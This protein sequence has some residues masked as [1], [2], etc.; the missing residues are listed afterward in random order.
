VLLGRSLGAAIAAELAQ[1]RAA[2]AVILE[3]PFK[4][5]PAVA[6]DV[7]PFL[8]ARWLA[9]IEYPTVRYVRNI[10]TPLLVIHSR[11]DEIIPFAH[12]RAVYDAANAPKRFLPITGGHNTGFTE[13][14]ERYTQGIDRFLTAVAG[15]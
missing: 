5:V 11:D 1:S 15:L 13:S 8:P 12:G 9:R 3:S 7:Y 2:G 4:S 6:Q 10:E 14:R